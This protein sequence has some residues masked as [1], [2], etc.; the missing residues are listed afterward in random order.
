M[1][2]LK[3]GTRVYSDMG[4]AKV[5]N[6][7]NPAE[8]SLSFTCPANC[9][10]L[11]LVVSG[12]PQEHWRHAWDDNYDNDESW[13]YQV[14]FANTNLLGKAT[15]I[16]GLELDVESNLVAIFPNPSHDNFEILLPEPSDVEVY[17]LDG[18][19]QLSYKKI[20]AVKFGEELKTGVY[21]VKAGNS[22][23]KIIK[24]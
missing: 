10:R 14:Q 6:G 13:P 19:L 20:R 22:F 8:Q 18:I 2:L 23:H 16:T 4:K 12:A 5:T 21:L 15:V 9:S 11:W 1:A 7:V 3:D 17:S 24:E